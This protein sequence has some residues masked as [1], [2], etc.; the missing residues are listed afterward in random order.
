MALFPMLANVVAALCGMLS[1]AAMGRL[2]LYPGL[3]PILA[4]FVSLGVGGL[5]NLALPSI[6][7][8]LIKWGSFVL[9][10]FVVLAITWA[11]FDALVHDNGFMTSSDIISANWS[12]IVTCIPCSGVSS[13]FSLFVEQATT[14]SV[15]TFCRQHCLYIY[16][17]QGT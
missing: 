8:F 9:R 15:E 10:G 5:T 14:V 12:K 4:L 7:N 1:P 17:S 2:I 6:S 16:T 3:R 13:S 11:V